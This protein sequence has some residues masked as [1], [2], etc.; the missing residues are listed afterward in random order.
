MSAAKHA[1]TAVLID[2]LSAS[3]ERAKTRDFASSEG[4]QSMFEVL[5]WAGAVRDRF[6]DDGTQIPSVLNGLWYV[7]NLAVHQGADVVWVIA[8]YGS[9][10]FGGSVFGGVDFGG[11]VG[12]A[13]AHVFPQRSGLPAGKSTLGAI[14]YD[15]LIAGQP[16]TQVLERAVGEVTAAQTAGQ[17][18]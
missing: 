10:T 4:F 3:V 5:A 9:G 13:S 2:G 8:T 6:K 18:L 11:G 16:V 14:E 17:S 7:R 12:G 1:T 15:K